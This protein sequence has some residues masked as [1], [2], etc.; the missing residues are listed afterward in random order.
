MNLSEIWKNKKQIAEGIKNNIFKQEHIEEVY[1]HRLQTCQTCPYYDPKGEFE[2]AY[3]PGSPSCG[4]CGCPL[5]NKLRS[6][7]TKC[8]EGFWNAITDEITEFKIEQQI[9]KNK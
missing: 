6:L 4:S 1:N 3:F 8:P 2:N 5:A 7:S 9:K